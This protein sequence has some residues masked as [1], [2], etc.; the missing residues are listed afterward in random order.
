[1]PDRPREVYDQRAR[2]EL[3][4]TLMRQRGIE[5]AAITPVMVQV[6]ST[7]SSYGQGLLHAVGVD[8]DSLRFCGASFE[9]WARTADALAGFADATLTETGEETAAAAE[10]FLRRNGQ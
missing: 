10:E 8:P 7:M 2:E 1:M 5:P 3:L 4:R 6:S 9:L